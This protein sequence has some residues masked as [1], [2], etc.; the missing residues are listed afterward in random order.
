[1]G[2]STFLGNRLKMSLQIVDE[3]SRDLEL[4]AIGKFEHVLP[5]RSGARLSH[6]SEVHKRGT[7]NLHKISR[8]QFRH[9]L[10]QGHANKACLVCQMK[11]DV[12]SI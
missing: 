7:M 12:I 1:M 5:E 10:V 8:R 3:S 2:P 9:H 4:R 11:P 6:V